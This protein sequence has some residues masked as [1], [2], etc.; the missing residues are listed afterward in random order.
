[1]KNALPNVVTQQIHSTFGLPLEEVMQVQ[2]GVGRS[3]SGGREVKGKMGRTRG[4]ARGEGGRYGKGERTRKD[5]G[6]GKWE[7]RWRRG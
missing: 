6:K 5:G 4:S 2:T 3:W 7:G 1:M